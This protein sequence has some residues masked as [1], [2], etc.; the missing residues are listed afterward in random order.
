MGTKKFEK[1]T[2]TFSNH[3][4]NPNQTWVKW[5][6]VV[7]MENG[8]RLKIASVSK[9]NQSREYVDGWTHIN[10]VWTNFT[11]LPQNTCHRAY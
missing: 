11:V 10:E 3:T 1:P 6:K 9:R 2:L 8:E 7:R 5:V 4:L